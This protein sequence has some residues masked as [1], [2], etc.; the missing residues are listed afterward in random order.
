MI[1]DK[2]ENRYLSFGQEYLSCLYKAVTLMGYY[3]MLRI[4]ELT[5]GTHPVLA[6]NIYVDRD[7]CELQLVLYTSKTHTKAN[8]PEIITITPSIELDP[9]QRFSNRYYP[10][11]VIVEFCNMRKGYR[12]PS[13][14][15]LFSEMGH[16]LNPVTLEQFS[17]GLFQK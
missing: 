9:R 13:D 3:G 17:E 8:L 11:Q 10:Y 15:S 2:I 12:R 7:R 16:W 1:I 4:G 6:V 5:S 14:P